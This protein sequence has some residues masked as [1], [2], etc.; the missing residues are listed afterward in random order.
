MEIIENTSKNYNMKAEYAAEIVPLMMQLSEACERIGLPYLIH[1]V[2]TETADG[3]GTGTLM[4]K[5]GKSGYAAD[6][7]ALLGAM[8]A[9]KINGDALVKATL[10]AG[11]ES[12]I[13]KRGRC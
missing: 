5:S 10:A 12:G 1:V 13:I 2:Y 3:I 6:Q 8:A 7:C 9:H 11:L 4:D